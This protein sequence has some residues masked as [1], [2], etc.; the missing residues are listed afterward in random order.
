[1]RTA[2]NLYSSKSQAALSVELSEISVHKS[3][4]FGHTIDIDY[5]DQ[6]CA[7][8]FNDGSALYLGIN[9]WFILEQL[10]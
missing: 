8:K 2:T 10:I 1:M 6:Y 3:D 9:G 4:F 5:L 7:V